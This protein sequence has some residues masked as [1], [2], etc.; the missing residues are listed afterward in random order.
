MGSMATGDREPEGFRALRFKKVLA[1]AFLVSAMWP[2]AM[3]IET[4]LLNDCADQGARWI[5]HHLTFGFIHHTAFPVAAAALLSIVEWRSIT[6]GS[7]IVLALIC[8][9]VVGLMV[10]DFRSIPTKPYMLQEP[11]EALT[12]ENELRELDDRQIEIESRIEVEVAA[13]EL[14]SRIDGTSELA[15]ENGRNKRLT[16]LRREREQSL[17]TYKSSV[18]KLRSALA[19]RGA[20]ARR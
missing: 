6:K 15:D 13:A 18:G 3:V 14:D 9:V 1:A 4:G 5:R 16:E 2:I 20:S 8:V 7:R 17:L 12:V 10:E 11:C 19:A